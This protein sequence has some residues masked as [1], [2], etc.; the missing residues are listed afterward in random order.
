MP[1]HSE[2]IWESFDALWRR[3]G[4]LNRRVRELEDRLVIL[5]RSDFEAVKDALGSEAVVSGRLGS[6][7]SAYEGEIQK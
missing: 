7:D 3:V 1:F 6:Q 5:E 2:E 4:Q